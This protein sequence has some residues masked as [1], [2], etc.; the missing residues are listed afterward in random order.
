MLGNYYSELLRVR[1]RVSVRVE[2]RVRGP[3]KILSSNFPSRCFGENHDHFLQFM[4]TLAFQ[5][6]PLVCAETLKANTQIPQFFHFD[7]TKDH[8]IPTG[9]H[10]VIT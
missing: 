6:Y 1:V 5:H 2:V 4:T 9:Y 10:K 8:S 3:V 7:R